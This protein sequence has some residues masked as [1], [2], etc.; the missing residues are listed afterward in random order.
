MGMFLVNKGTDC[1]V[2]APNKEL[3]SHNMKPH[4]TKRATVF[5]K[6]ELKA[7]PTGISP[8]ACGPR[9]PGIGSEVASRGWYIFEAA[10]VGMQ[11]WRLVVQFNDVQYG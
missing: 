7:D 11:G 5:A 2:V 8:M 3:N 6:S 9:G 1:Y 10:Q 4:R